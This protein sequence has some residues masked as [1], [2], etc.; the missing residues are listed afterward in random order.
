VK[1][2]R[3]TVIRPSKQVNSNGEPFPDVCTLPMHRFDVF[4]IPRKHVVTERDISRID[5]LMYDEYGYANYDDIVLMY[6]GVG[7]VHQLEPG[8]TILLP[9]KKDIERF[10]A[11]HSQ[12]KKKVG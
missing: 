8:D 12:G 1:K 7:S 11:K 10:F 3:Y 4:G 5:M 6:N 9:P 2:S